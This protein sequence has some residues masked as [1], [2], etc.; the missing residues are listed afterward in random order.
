MKTV[1]LGWVVF[2]GAVIVGCSGGSSS[3]P[4]SDGGTHEDAPANHDAHAKD[5]SGHHDSGSD[6]EKPGHD[7]AGETGTLPE[8]SFDAGM[9]P[10]VTSTMTSGTRLKGEWY[11]SEGLSRFKS[12]YDTVLSQE[13]QWGYA[14]D[15]MLRCLPTQPYGSAEVSYVSF[16]DDHCT[17][18]VALVPGGLP[19][20]QIPTS[21]DV[22]AVTAPGCPVLTTYYAFGAALVNPTMVYR[23]SSTTTCFG[24]PPDSEDVYYAL[25]PIAP[26]TYVPGTESVG[27]ASANLTAIT[28]SGDD[29]SVT[30]E[31]LRDTANGSVDCAFGE[32]TDQA[33]HCLPEA[34]IALQIGEFSDPACTALVATTFP[35]TCTN[36]SFITSAVAP[37]C[38]PAVT[39]NALGAPLTTA[40]VQSGTCESTPVQPDTYSPVG[41]VA[42]PAKFTEGSVSVGPSSGRLAP[43]LVTAGAI[44]A[45]AV[46]ISTWDSVLPSIEY[47]DT[48]R[49]EVCTPLLAHDDTVRC[50]P[51]ALEDPASYAYVS[52]SLYADSACKVSVGVAGVGCT[53]PVYAFGA[54]LP[55]C[56]VVENLVYPVTGVTT[57]LYS[58]QGATCTAQTPVAGNVYYALGPEV[59]ASSFA[60]I[61]KDIH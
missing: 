26:T 44:V 23:G 4:S 18:P 31:T 39:V 10:T 49:H 22:Y 9:T 59:S 8:A 45:D 33:R 15:G 2:G 14:A 3:T 50:L 13:C 16:S 54:A 42:A 5:D 58:L 51:Y 27:T 32:A 47:E 21:A 17:N 25:T 35:S 40:Y 12:I 52:D 53:T 24:G 55:T 57:S 41:A 38:P 30:F 19:S 60:P 34:Q 46:S 48:S 7:A 29:G 43:R 1:C 61:T 56:G 11:D 28:V 20:C 36:P 6:A 37:A